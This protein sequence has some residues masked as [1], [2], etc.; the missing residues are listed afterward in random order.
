MF[1]NDRKKAIRYLYMH[2]FGAPKERDWHKM[3]LILSIFHMLSIPKNSYSRVKELLHEVSREKGDN[4]GNKNASG[5]KALLIHGTT[6][7]NIIYKALLN[8][9]TTKD[10]T[11]VLNMYR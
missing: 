9:L 4:I 3:K 1:Y 6:Q 10:A 2:V 11:C 7:A 5:R 8:G